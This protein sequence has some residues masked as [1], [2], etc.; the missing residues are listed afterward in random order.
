[1]RQTSR[2]AGAGSGFTLVELM[3]TVLIAGIVFAAMVPLFVTAAS[4]ASG[5]RSRTTIAVNAAQARIEAI[6]ALPFDQIAADPTNEAANQA[7][8]NL[9]DPS[10]GSGQFG[11]AYTPSGSSKAYSV[12]YAVTSVPATGIAN[13][14]QITVTVSWTA[15]PS[16]VYP[17][18]LTTTVM[19]PAAAGAGSPSATP[20]PTPTSTST[21]SPSPTP[22]PSPTTGTY[23]LTILVN[24]SD[25]TGISV[26]RSDVTPSVTELPTSQVATTAAPVSWTGLPGGSSITYL[27]TCNYTKPGNPHQGQ[28]EQLQQTVTLTGSVSYTFDTSK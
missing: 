6:R 20:T 3:V 18:T 28:A 14:K 2:T 15:P 1:M 10:F 24:T 12:G 21:S 16:P 17:T 22:T 26:V 19:N 9:Y 4:K 7:T 8:P 25:V 5:N 13:Y 23:T 27:V 11:P